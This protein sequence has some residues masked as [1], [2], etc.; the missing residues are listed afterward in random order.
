MVGEDEHGMVVGRVL[1]PPAA[2]RLIWPRSSDRAE[3]V[4]AHD[5][6]ANV[7]PALRYN[8][9]AR[10]VLASISAVHLSEFLERKEPLVQFHPAHAE[11]VLLALVGAT[12]VAVQR[13]RDAE[14]QLAHVH[15]LAC[16]ALPC[17]NRPPGETGLI[18]GCARCRS[19][20]VPGTRR[21]DR[22]PSSPR[23]RTCLSG[24]SIQAATP[25]G[26]PAYF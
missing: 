4:A 24:H 9:R 21:S 20:R 1:A 23:M 14:P 5:R 26:N 12:C 22:R 15:S 13:H 3:H 17:S 19:N 18:G 6:G 11:R 25:F 2:P 16:L 8:G 10:V 7:C